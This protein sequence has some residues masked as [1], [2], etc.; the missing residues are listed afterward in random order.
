VI[1][2]ITP[3]PLLVLIMACVNASTLLLAR[4]ARRGH[5]LAIRLAIG[6][7]RARVVRQLLI[8]SLLLGLLAAGAG[9]LLASWGLGAAGRQLSLSMPI[10]ASVLVR[11]LLVTLASVAASGLAPAL[12]VTARTPFRA[13]GTAHA[14]PADVQ[15]APRGRRLIVAQI[16]LSIGVLTTATQLAAMIAARGGSAGTP[17]DRLL[18]ASFD[19]DQ[20][21]FTP[22][23]AERFYAALVDR[24]SNL[25]GVEN[26]GL[27]RGTAVWG[28]NTPPASIA[29]LVV[30]QPGATA[31]DAGV[32]LGGYAGGD[33][34]R[35]VGLAVLEGRT[36]VPEDRHGWPRV[37][38]VNDAYAKRIQGPALGRTLHVGLVQRGGHIDDGAFASGRDVEIVGVIQSASEPRYDV[39]G[40]PVPKIYLPAP[41]QPEPALTLY[42][43][44]RS[45]AETV[46]APLRDLVHAI[47][48]RV[49]ILEIG[50]LTTWNER[51][52]EWAP[53]LMRAATC[54]GLLSL[55]L[56]AAGLLAVV[57]YAV[58]ARGREFAIRMALG[59][60]P[61]GV[62]AL[63][64]REAMRL[65]IAGFVIGGGLALLATKL[66][67]TRFYGAQ[68]LDVYAFAGSIALLIVVMLLASA[69]PAIRAARVD[70]VAAL[71]EG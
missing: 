39:D 61:R 44:T 9:L 47:D 57:S 24:A 43:R 5:E 33:L 46:A 13:M 6:A 34:F 42:L 60:H 35:A 4:G 18:M 64:L 29:A 17:P 36:F 8:E 32:I 70:P 53:W 63:V 67:Q 55:A 62:L 14:D 27:A 48:P 30:W 1:L 38:V 45:K 26:A 2:S 20:L 21:R 71:K 3:I 16:A 31:K 10:D 11:A 65:V 49:P 41:L 58:A 66:L 15:R 52:M 68:G 7:G 54:M 40:T 23:S 37:A 69:V 59:S 51:S 50:S 22:E 56:A 12:H 25:P 19:L 28:L